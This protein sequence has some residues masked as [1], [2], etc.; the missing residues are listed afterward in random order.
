MDAKFADLVP[1][2]LLNCRQSAIAIQDALDR[3]DHATVE[4]LGHGMR[5]AGGSYGFEPISEL[6]GALERAA[7]AGDTD[8]MQRASWRRVVR[9]S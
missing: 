5:G 1:A 4:T 6:G 3:H 2:F 9:L 8:G 7:A